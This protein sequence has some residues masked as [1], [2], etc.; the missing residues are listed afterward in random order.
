MK[1]INS[2]IKTITYYF[3]FFILLQSC[4]VYRT[5]PV[6]VETAAEKAGRV[7]IKTSDNATYK[8]RRLEQ[9]GSGAIGIAGK[10]S[11]AV[12]NLEH[13]IVEENYTGNFVKINLPENLIKEV[14]LKKQ[15]LSTSLTIL[16]IVSVIS[17]SLMVA[18]FISFSKAFNSMFT[19]ETE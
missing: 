15:G 13:L 6:T 18:M 11:R 2:N 7:K 5:K 1:T 12:R 16:S 4:S 14:R 17:F 10:N 8:F 19:G 9:D 3:I